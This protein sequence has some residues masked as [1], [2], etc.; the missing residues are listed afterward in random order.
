MT[1]VLIRDGKLNMLADSDSSGIVFQLPHRERVD[2]S[3]TFEPLTATPNLEVAFSE[4]ESIIV[5]DA[6]LSWNKFKY[7]EQDGSGQLARREDR[8]TMPIPLR[9]QVGQTYTVTISKRFGEYEF[10]LE[11]E[12]SSSGGPYATT[13]SVP[14]ERR[15]DQKQPYVQLWVRPNTFSNLRNTRAEVIIDEIFSAL[16]D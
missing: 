7:A 4:H 12:N 1:E 2:L 9:M 14:N 15:P 16:P 5:G 13:F 3:L 11:T 8:R 6:I 10:S